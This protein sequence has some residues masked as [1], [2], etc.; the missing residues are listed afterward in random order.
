MAR[1]RLFGKLR[2]I[3][4][5][6]LWERRETGRQRDGQQPVLTRRQL[7][8]G[9][10]QLLAATGLAACSGEDD[11]GDSLRRERV[12]VVGAGIAGLH[13]AYRLQQSG[14]DVTVYEAANRV[15]GRMF[16]AR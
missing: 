12:A 3:A 16:T 11:S 7:T 15:G 14:V 4:S 5:R 13:C 1:T 2:R 8:L 9:T 10:A 6:A